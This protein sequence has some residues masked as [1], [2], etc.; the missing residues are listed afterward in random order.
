[1]SE[2]KSHWE[3][4]YKTKDHKKVGWYQESPESSLQL[5]AKIHAHPDQSLIDVGCGASMLVDK[6]L[7]QGYK[8]ITLLDLSSKALFAIKTRLSD[9][10]NIP[11]YIDQDITKTSLNRAF[12]IWHD[13]AVFHFLTNA[14]DRNNY[15]V[16]LANCLAKNGRA[17]I[18]TFSLNGPD[19]CSGLDIVQYDEEKMASELKGDLEIDYSEITVHVQPGGAEQEYI[20]FIIKHKNAH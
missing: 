3:N 16:N 17:I 14:Q 15:M 11:L 13:R 18:G 5:L 2:R 20:F 1:M 12:D 8:D 4:I 19:K 10:A 9:K 7:E 6:L